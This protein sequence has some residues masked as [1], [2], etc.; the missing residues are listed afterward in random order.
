MSWTVAGEPGAAGRR[1]VW[2][3]GG[4]GVSSS[5]ASHWPGDLGRFP[6]PSVQGEAPRW[7][8]SDR[9]FPLGPTDSQVM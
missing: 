9:K 7:Y 4:P 1:R 5:S 8:H 2:G 3:G 6:D